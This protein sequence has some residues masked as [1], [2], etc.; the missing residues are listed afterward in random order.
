MS[1]FEQ[2]DNRGMA[3]KNDR[4]RSERDPGYTGS[5]RVDGEDYY[6]S[7]WVEDDRR[8][9]GAK[10]L[11]IA[12]NPKDRNRAAGSGSTTTRS[13]ADDFSDDDIPF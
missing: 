2:K 11:S 5:I 8:N 9:P 6:V 13:A 3:W 12:V 1:G 7:V 10:R 4:K